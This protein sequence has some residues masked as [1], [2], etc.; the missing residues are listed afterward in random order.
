MKDN[1]VTVSGSLASSGEGVARI[2]F[3]EKDG[4]VDINLY[5]APVMPFNS[6]SFRKTYTAKTGPIRTVTLAGVVRYENGKEISAAPD[7][8]DK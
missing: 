4:S 2:T 5:T 1:T 8:M 6:G 7:R 3:S